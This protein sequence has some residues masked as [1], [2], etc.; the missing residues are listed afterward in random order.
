MW[1]FA[2][3]REDCN[4]AVADGLNMADA[5][6]FRICQARTWQIN[7]V[8]GLHAWKPDPAE[9]S[10][11]VLA[12]ERSALVSPTAKQLDRA[13]IVRAVIKTLVVVGSGALLDIADLPEL[14]TRLGMFGS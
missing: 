5:H 2:E 6:F 1:F 11:N 12:D 8:D 4:V 10:S 13:T 7:L 3:D 14:V 9:D